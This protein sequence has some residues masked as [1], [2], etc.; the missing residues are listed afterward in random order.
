MTHGDMKART[1]QYRRRRRRFLLAGARVSA[2]RPVLSAATAMA[3]LPSSGSWSVSLPELELV[4]DLR[5]QGLQ[6]GLEVRD[7]PGEVLVDE[8]VVQVRVAEAELR[9]LL[10]AGV[11]VSED[12]HERG[13]VR[14]VGEHLVPHRGDDRRDVEQLLCQARLALGA[15]RQVLDEHPRLTGMLGPSGDADGAPSDLPRPVQLR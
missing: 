15:E 5:R 12:P 4:V 3:S 2:A 8:R 7:L 13:E 14:V 6:P 9:D 1:T 11:R 10:V